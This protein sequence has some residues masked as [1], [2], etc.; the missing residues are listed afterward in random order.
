M[1]AAAALVLTAILGACS[2]SPAA[3]PSES[4]SSLPSA[5]A[6]PS[7]TPQPLPA[8]VN[9]EE[10]GALRIEALP[11]ADWVT[12][13][14]DSA[15]VA[16]VGSGIGR[17]DLLTGA[18]TGDV[19]VPG[20]ICLAMDAGFGSLWAGNCSH[21]TLV[22]VDVATGEV[23]ATIPL[24]ESPHQESS[25]AV[26]DD[27]VWLITSGSGLPQLTKVDP[28]T[29]A[30]V[31]TYDSLPLATSVRAGFGGLW[32]SDGE[33]V[34]H[35]NPAD[36]SVV[37]VIPA[38]FGANFLAVGEGGVW[39]LNGGDGTVTRIDPATDSVVATI[40]VSEV[41]VSGGD[42]AVGGGAVWARISDVLV[43]QIDVATNTVVARYGPGFGSGSVAADDDALWVSAHDVE[44]IWR[45]PLR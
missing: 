36:G 10:E 30:V 40:R 19:S 33:S 14:G 34:T 44:A 31:A 32:V 27:A 6:S 16:G 45:L 42:I 12:L 8:E 38:G 41:G 9:I 25:V 17:F 18:P 37:A 23:T 20:F 35:V 29:N 24:P 26:G 3:S 13:A 21:K 43:A 1:R 4:E 22:R 28:A 2:P 11:A 5:S 15:W 39:V 7:G